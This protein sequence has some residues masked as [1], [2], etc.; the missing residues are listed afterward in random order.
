MH[1]IFNNLDV[2]LLARLFFVV[3]I[4]KPYLTIYINKNTPTFFPIVIIGVNMLLE[5]TPIHFIIFFILEYDWILFL[6]QM[7][8]IILFNVFISNFPKIC[9]FILFKCFKKSFK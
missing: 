7:F 9:H 1:H 3:A 5:L 6:N 4:S 2:E 8:F